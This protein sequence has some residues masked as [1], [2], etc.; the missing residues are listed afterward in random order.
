MALDPAGDL[1]PSY[2]LIAHPWKNCGRP[3]KLLC[4]CLAVLVRPE[5]NLRARHLCS[6]PRRLTPDVRLRGGDRLTDIYSISQ[7][8][9]QSVDHEI[10][11][12]LHRFGL[13]WEYK[14]Q[15]N[16][17]KGRELELKYTFQKVRFK[18]KI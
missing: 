4:R 9:S 5:F 14:S 8:V 10:V 1:R 3:C 13:A 16:T 15:Q 2:P 17:L 12:G 7:W 18:T 11:R 6:R